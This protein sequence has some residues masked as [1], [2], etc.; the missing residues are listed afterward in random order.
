MRQV[1]HQGS[2]PRKRDHRV[3]IAAAKNVS[4]NN[5]MLDVRTCIMYC[6]ALYVPPKKS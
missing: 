3:L 6:R 2:A 4:G 1:L 5:I